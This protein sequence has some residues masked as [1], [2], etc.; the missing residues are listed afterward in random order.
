ME[1]S[2]NHARIGDKDYPVIRS[3]LRAWLQLEDIRSDILDAARVG[4]KD[5]FV[6]SMYSYV[7]TAFSIPVEELSECFWAE[8]TRA[9]LLVHNENAPNLNLPLIKP[10]ASRPT[11]A[12]EKVDGWE[13]PGRTWYFWLNTFSRN[14]GWSI[15]YIAELNVDDAFSLIQEIF[16]DEQLDREWQWSLSEN[17]VSY[18]ASTKKTKFNPLSRPDWMKPISEVMRDIPKVK[19]RS[20][21][22]PV[23]LIYR[24]DNDRNQPQ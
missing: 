4:D 5:K 1:T 8:I 3:K 16:V 15:E 18:D 22:M 17:S 2:S 21:E 12:L 9:Y 7:S 10:K 13:Y 11:P 24:W 23:G 6:S 19:I 14:Y 20:S